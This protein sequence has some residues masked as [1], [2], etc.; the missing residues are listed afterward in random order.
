MHLLVFIAALV[1]SAVF[2]RWVRDY[3]IARGWACIPSSD[4]HVHNR[5]IP[6]LGGVAIFLTLCC[7]ALLAHWLPGYFGTREFP[8]SHL[9]LT[10]IV[11]PPII[12]VLRVTYDFY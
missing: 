6:R 1:T 7:M 9:I 5:P 3:S 8:L 10:I 2:T 11:L 4:R 12:F